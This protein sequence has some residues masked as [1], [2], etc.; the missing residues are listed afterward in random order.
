ML[1]ELRLV[2]RRRAS[3]Q[4]LVLH[5]AKRRLSGFRGSWWWVGWFG[6]GTATLTR[7]LTNRHLYFNDSGDTSDGDGLLDTAVSADLP[8]QRRAL[9]E[10]HRAPPDFGAGRS[11]PRGGE[12]GLDRGRSCHLRDPARAGSRPAR[13]PQARGALHAAEV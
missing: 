13:A 12:G 11:P 2:K 4:T 8:L 5:L 1:R 3:R 10:R 9:R 6:L 7:G